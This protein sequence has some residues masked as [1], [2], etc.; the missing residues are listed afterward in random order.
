MVKEIQIKGNPDVE[1]HVPHA[2][3]IFSI[4][5]SS[6]TTAMNSPMVITTF[7]RMWARIQRPSILLIQKEFSEFFY[8]VAELFGRFFRKRDVELC[9]VHNH[10]FSRKANAY[11]EIGAIYLIKKGLKERS[12]LGQDV[13]GGL[14]VSG[15]ERGLEV[16][17]AFLFLNQLL[18]D[19]LDVY[20][21][22]STT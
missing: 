14:G 3:T 18:D 13:R 8:V 7:T 11:I 4:A 19:L 2:N 5:L 20:L 10:F 22:H 9:A 17:R 1:L 21:A 15:L 16:G 6:N 12:E